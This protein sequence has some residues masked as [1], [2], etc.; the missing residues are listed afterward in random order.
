MSRLAFL[1]VGIGLCAC[2]GTGL[3][4][5][6]GDVPSSAHHNGERNPVGN[7]IGSPVGSDSVSQMESQT[8]IPITRN[9]L[10]GTW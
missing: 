9:A 4:S 6:P 7:P 10:S 5:R 8:A 3:S 2:G 1:L